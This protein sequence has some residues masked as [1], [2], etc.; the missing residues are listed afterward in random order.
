MLQRYMKT[1]S[2]ELHI[3]SLQRSF[4]YE[5][6][7]FSCCRVRECTDTINLS[8]ITCLKYNFLNTSG[9]DWLQ[10]PYIE[11]LGSGATPHQIDTNHE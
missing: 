1:E 7:T 5:Q 8:Q 3:T 10:G 9:N 4:H 11:F 6:T 2:A